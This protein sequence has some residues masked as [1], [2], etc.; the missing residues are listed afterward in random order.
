MPH[1]HES[2]DSG[3]R[4]RDFPDKLEEH[5]NVNTGDERMDWL[6]R[7]EAAGADSMGFVRKNHPR[8][9]RRRDPSDRETEH[10]PLGTNPQSPVHPFGMTSMAAQI[11]IRRIERRRGG[12]GGCCQRPAAREKLQI[13]LRVPLSPSPSDWASR[14]DRSGSVTD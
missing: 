12:T 7:S 6:A 13:R 1:G 3:K 5:E 2:V 9:S 11:P 14:M 4:H 10:V 8:L